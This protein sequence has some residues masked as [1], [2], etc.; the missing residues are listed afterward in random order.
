MI[1][2]IIPTY[3]HS[4]ELKKCLES[5]FKQTYKDFEVIVVNDGS[6]DNT[7]EL[8]NNLKH[9][10][11]WPIQIV[12]QPHLGRN[13]ARNHGF[14]KAKGQFLLFCDADVEMRPV[15]LET[16]LQT[17]Q[18]HPEAS[19][20]YSSFKFGWKTFKLGP[21]DP[22]LLKKMPYI[23]TTSLIRREHFPGFDEKIQKFQDWDLWLTMLE[24]GHIGI[25]IPEVLYRITPNKT[26]LSRWVPSFF[27]HL[28]WNIF[29]KKP[30]TVIA[31]EEAMAI[32]KKKHQ[33]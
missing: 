17:L 8:L 21:F 2:I 19:Y 26:G 9:S 29:G 7:L 14:Q 13:P 12:S 33:L 6:T 20:A 5:I 25:W 28:P 24:Q 22:E 18:N 4:Q 16:M 15:M 11:G 31:Y 1:S 27:Y 32:I 3:N 23:H 10:K 30:K